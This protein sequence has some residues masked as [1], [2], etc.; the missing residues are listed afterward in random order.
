[1]GAT[2]KEIIIRAIL[3][4]TPYQRGTA[5]RQNAERSL[6]KL[7][8][9]TLMLLA[10][11]SN[12][13]MIE[14]DAAAFEIAREQNYAIDRQRRKIRGE[15]LE[16]LRDAAIAWA[17]AVPAHPWLISS[18]E[19]MHECFIVELSLSREGAGEWAIR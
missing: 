2:G 11:A 16:L 5:I 10:H 12:V 9:E 18:G 14:K 7:S 19:Y 13:I 6:L 15:K 8:N 1:M 3:N 17:W 4:K